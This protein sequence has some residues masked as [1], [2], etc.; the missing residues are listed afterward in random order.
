[1]KP[2]VVQ[3][4]L[5]FSAYPLK[6]ITG[7][8]STK[9]SSATESPYLKSVLGKTKTITRVRVFAMV[10]PYTKPIAKA[11][12][13]VRPLKDKLPGNIELLE[14]EWYNNYE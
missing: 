7:E 12:K 1:M 10:N 8:T 11:K 2:E 13:P 14:R 9:Q 4:S 3:S 6:A 5:Y